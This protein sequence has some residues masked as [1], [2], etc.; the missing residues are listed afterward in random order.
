MDAPTTVLSVRDFPAEL[1]RRA[2]AL[3]AREGRSLRE[4]VIA[5]V[6]SYVGKGDTPAWPGPS[7]RPAPKAPAGVV[8]DETEEC[9][10]CQ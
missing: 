1:H 10:A 6:E 4:V 3:A 8:V 9:E 2:K 5:A 7:P